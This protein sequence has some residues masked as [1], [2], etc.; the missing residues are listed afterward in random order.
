MIRFREGKLRA[1]PEKCDAL[2]GLKMRV[3]AKSKVSVSFVT[4]GTGFGV[5]F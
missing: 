5:A 3:K 2:F 1:Y 4:H